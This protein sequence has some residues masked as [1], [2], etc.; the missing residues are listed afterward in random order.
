[1]L[2][3][4]NSSE[5][6]GKKKQKDISILIIKNILIFPKSIYRKKEIV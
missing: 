1:M 4:M 2:E 3:K 6:S 5:N